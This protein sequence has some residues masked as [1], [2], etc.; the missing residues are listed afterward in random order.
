MK[1]SSV[2]VNTLEKRYRKKVEKEM[3]GTLDNTKKAKK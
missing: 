1:F 3:A 2:V